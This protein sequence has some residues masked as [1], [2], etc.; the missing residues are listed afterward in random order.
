MLMT[1]TTAACNATTTTGTTTLTT[2][3]INE[4]LGYIPVTPYETIYGTA[5]T[6]PY[7]EDPTASVRKA[8]HGY[9]LT[10]QQGYNSWYYEISVNGAF[11]ELDYD[12][13]ASR[14]GD[15]LN[16]VA[17]AVQTAAGTAAVAKTFLVPSAMAG[18]IVIT[19]NVRPN[20]SSGGF[21]IFVNDAKIYPANAD[22]LDVG[23]EIATG[24]FYSIDA[25]VE[26][27][28]RIRFVVTGGSVAT[29]PAIIKGSLTETSL[30]FDFMNE[31]FDND[32][33]RH[34]GDV[35]PFYHDGKLYM[36][37]LE[38]N[39]RYTSALLE[40]ADFVTYTENAIRTGTPSPSISTYFVLGITKY[41]NTFVSFFGASATQ[42]NSSYSTNLYEWKNHNGVGNIPATENVSARDPYVFYDPDV[43]RFR[44]VYLSYYAN[45]RNAGGDFD[46][47][48]WLKTST[49]SNPD[50][51]DAG[52]VEL[53]R[54]DNAGA[55]GKE[56][57]EVSQMVKIGTRWYLIA[58]IYSRTVH[59]VGGFSYWKGDENTVITDVD[60]KSKQEQFLDGE[61]LCAGQLV[62]VGDRWYLF[63]WIPANA[64]SSQWG[65]ALTLAREVYQLKNGDLAVRLD[66][67]LTGLINRGTIL[68]LRDATPV[69]VYGTVTQEADKVA[70]LGGGE[71]RYGFDAFGEARLPGT[72][73]R[74]IVDYEIDLSDASS[75]AGLLLK[76][77]DTAMR[78]F[79]YVD[80]ASSAL[81]IYS[82]TPEGNFTRS[83]IAIAVADWST[84]R[85]KVIVDGSIV[86]VFLNDTYSLVGRVTTTGLN[87]LDD[88]QISLFV[89]GVAA[90][91]GI[92][93]SKLAARE[94][95]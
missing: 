71:A 1:I 62:Q 41:E 75:R 29:D 25:N 15:A 43:D 52:H 89:S 48:L 78:H 32:M 66:P 59:G 3:P 56:D 50:F 28:D 80:R 88:C 12:A 95:F 33:P 49:G 76:N 64:Q 87:E 37:Y 17:G 19:G 79:V 92:L 10:S 94:D 51:W 46:A 31:K 84:L 24:Y 69:S 45:N 85:L 40:S 90:F 57:P 5:R 23:N 47:A 61:D 53:L 72:Y 60:W 54:F 81:V 6:E 63:G 27:G 77:S 16:H 44:I 42:I 30:Y 93:V 38:T 11:A 21:A 8:S 2:N 67:H 65:G 35:H 70:V 58:S 91:S 14:W 9:T 73:G 55:S 34:I 86:D 82:R 36:Y 20:G 39:G 18:D 83:S 13:I 68:D 74:V 22:R 4:D 7:P 26:A